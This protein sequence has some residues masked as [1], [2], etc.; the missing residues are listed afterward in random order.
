MKKSDAKY[1]VDFHKWINENMDIKSEDFEY[2]AN[3]MM[4]SYNILTDV[5]NGID[6]CTEFSS[7]NYIIGFDP[8]DDSDKPSEYTI[9]DTSKFSSNA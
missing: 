8:Y 1:I 3:C 6:E 4:N 7:E 9:F 2:Y 5:V